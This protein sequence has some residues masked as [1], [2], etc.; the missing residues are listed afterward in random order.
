MFIMAVICILVMKIT[1]ALMQ[2]ITAT[3]I[4]ISRHFSSR[5]RGIPDTAKPAWKME[6]KVDFS[7]RIIEIH[8]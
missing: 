2:S 1:L 7:V 8:S 5:T 6:L 3:F 4:F